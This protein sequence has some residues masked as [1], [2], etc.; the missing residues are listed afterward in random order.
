MKNNNNEIKSMR[1]LSDQEKIERDEFLKNLMLRYVKTNRMFKLT[2]TIYCKLGVK[3]DTRDE[4][5][6][7]IK[8]DI[9]ETYEEFNRLDKSA[10]LQSLRKIIFNYIVEET[11]N[12]EVY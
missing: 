7:E 10:T 12:S 2:E 6:I 1:K 4:K 5:L 9:R 8:E 11:E 3:Y